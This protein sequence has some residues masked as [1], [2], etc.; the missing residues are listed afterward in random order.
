M[1]RVDLEL[2]PGMFLRV[3]RPDHVQR[4][5][6]RVEKVEWGAVELLELWRGET[7][8]KWTPGVRTYICALDRLSNAE[9]HPYPAPTPGDPVEG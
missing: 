6:Y 8:H 3:A 2:K 4:R 1:N 5:S 7:T 9:L